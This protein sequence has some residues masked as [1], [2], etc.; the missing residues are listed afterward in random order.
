MGKR[1]LFTGILFLFMMLAGCTAVNEK[2]EIPSPAAEHPQ[3]EHSSS[4]D[5]DVLIIATGDMSGVYFSLGQAI[6]AI[7]EKYNGIASAVQVT[8][9]SFQNTRLVSQ[10]KADI[11]FATLDVL[12][13]ME[14]DHSVDHLR[15][16]TGLYS[17][18]IHI[19]ALK[20]S[21]IT[22]LK[23]LEG[24]RISVGPDGSGTKLT[25]G[26]V[27]SAFGLNDKKV[28]KHFLTFSQSV[29]ALK[30]GTIDAAFIFSGL[31]NPE[32]ATLASQMPI[33]L[34][35]VP[36]EVVSNLHKE[37]GYYSVKMIPQDTYEGMKESV[38]TISVK[39]VLLVH[40]D[41]PEKQAYQ[42]VKTLY[43]HL[44]ELQKIHPAARDIIGTEAKAENPID[45]HPGAKKY[46]Q[47]K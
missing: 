12:S 29:D 4:Q 42:L 39:N 19:V 5:S 15:V 26:R 24:K 1:Q 23:D 11:G 21:G 44:P 3:S 20:H 7:Y 43:S 9:A 47:K 28:E 31:P 14:K 45:F 30:N 35:P 40:K 33:T 6:A 32:I 36:R 27:L 17:N 38:Q 13:E 10:K 46:F 41:L 18:Y 16:L 22:S 34:I 2:Q 37:H 25:A 8:N